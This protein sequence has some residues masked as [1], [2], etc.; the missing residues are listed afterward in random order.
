MPINVKIAEPE[1][2]APEKTEETIKISISN[3]QKMLLEFNSS[4]H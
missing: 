3:V 4:Y 2:K 1:A